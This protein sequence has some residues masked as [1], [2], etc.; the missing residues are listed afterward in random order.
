M[1]II[2]SS[3]DSLKNPYY[4]GGGAVAI[5]EVAKRLAADFEVMVITGKYSGSKDEVIDD[6]RYKRVGIPFFGPK[7]G[8]LA[9]QVCL[10]FSVMAEKYDVWMESFTP[11]FSTDCLQFFTKKPVIGLAHMLS[12]EDMKRKYKLPFD[13]IE[14][15][16]LAKYKHFIVLTETAKEKV[17]Q[18]NPLANIAVIPNGIDKPKSMRKIEARKYIL[19]LGRIEMNQKGLD[20]LLKAYKMIHKALGYKL[21]IAGAGE[22]QEMSKLKNLVKHLKLESNI[23]IVG[24]VEHSA[25]DKLY[26]GSLL[27]LLPSRYETYPM[28]A[29]EALS[30]GLPIVCFD[31]PGLKWLPQNCR[32]KIKP[33]DIK[34]LGKAILTILKDTTFRKK[35][36]ITGKK[37]VKK[38]D[39]DNVA[40]KYR[41]Y[42]QRVLKIN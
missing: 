35:A 22:A 42:I 34:A 37:F 33:F 38:M 29:L 2:I 18:R 17:L 3:Y 39:W 28:V 30:Y 6:V 8:Q 7:I 5:H 25:I 1:K 31:I 36:E 20:L 26:Q 10:P 9:Y 13:L 23:D 27:F 40:L 19:F 24:R 14:N 11:P 32:L 4:A 16:G 15:I 21:V 41:N 12:G